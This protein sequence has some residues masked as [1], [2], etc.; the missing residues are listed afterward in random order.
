MPQSPAILKMDEAHR[1]V[2]TELQTLQQ[3]RN[4][5]S[6]K[7]GEIKKSGGDAQEAMDAVSAIKDKM[8]GAGRKRT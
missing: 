4:E 8:G 3:E 6:K 1:A 7:I 2:Q 5:A